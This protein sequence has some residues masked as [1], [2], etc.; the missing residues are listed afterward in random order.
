MSCSLSRLLCPW[1][2]SR[3]EYRSGLP[4]PSPGH[5]PNPV[6]EP[7]SSTLQTDSLPSELPAKP[8]YV[9]MCV[10]VYIYKLYQFAVPE[11]IITL[12]INYMKYKIKSLKK[13][14][15]KCGTYLYTQTLLSPVKISIFNSTLYNSSGHFPAPKQRLKS[16]KRRK[17]WRIKLPV[18]MLG[19]DLQRAKLLLVHYLVWKLACGYNWIRLFS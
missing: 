19:S 8:M 6:T 12:L 9:C 13:K 7:R 4:C 18:L 10:C 16:L 15:R 17:K 14:K 3:Q 11:A 5:L 2:F 1:E